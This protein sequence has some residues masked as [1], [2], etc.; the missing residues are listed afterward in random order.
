MPL[1]DLDEAVARYQALP[2]IEPDEPG[3][4]T[5]ARVAE[6]SP[7]DNE[8]DAQV[9][10]A[11]TVPST[12]DTARR[13]LK[14]TQQTIRWQTDTFYQ[15]VGTHYR[16]RRDSDLRNE[17]LR[18]LDLYTPKAKPRLASDVLGCLAAETRIAETVE[19][20]AFLRD[21]DLQPDDVIAFTNGLLS[22]GR[23]LNGDCTLRPHTADYFSTFCL[24]YGFNPKADCP[25]WDKTVDEIFEGDRECIDL[26]Y[27]WFGLCLTWDTKYHAIML[28]EG[29]PRS[30]KGTV[31]RTLERVIGK[32]NC[33]SPLLSTLGERF[34]LWNLL[35][36][37]VAT[38]SD[39]H[40]GHGDKALA[41]LEI[42]K[43]VSGEDAIDVDRKGIAPLRA[44]LRVRFTL[45]VNELPRFGDNAN[46]L[47]SR[48]LILPFRRSFVGIE[49]RDLDDKLAPEV[50][51]VF[52]KALQGLGRLRR[53]GRFTT[54]EIAKDVA[55]DFARLVSP[56][57]AFLEDSC[58][59]EPGAT[60]FCE[61]IWA[62]WQTYA[63]LNGYF[64]GSKETLGARLKSLIP[65]L[66]TTRPRTD[67]R[68]LRCYVGVGLQD[69]ARPYGSAPTCSESQGGPRG[70][71]EFSFPHAQEG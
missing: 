62:A 64:D 66:L 71:R 37:R 45:A 28:C 17:I 18:W 34:G 44:R 59:V 26:L 29:P 46:A 27:E 51:G 6:V 42:L 70:P 4:G 24:P 9:L 14:E 25:V 23:A 53:Q 67:G 22:V 68:R 20:P 11:P 7:T 39:A 10:A 3:D 55:R 13:F 32:E 8:L 69:H 63:K 40:L 2:P 21:T 30:G 58:I 33:A 43:A 35:N 31:T 19:A 52:N 47:A 12:F 16:V 65:N 60:E 5:S 41:V 1:P 15:Y 61:T 56:I 54:P 48:V 49:D 50:A 36:K 38:I 57:K